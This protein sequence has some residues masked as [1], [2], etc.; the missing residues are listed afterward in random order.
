MPLTRS[1]DNPW[2]EIRVIVRLVKQHCSVSEPTQIKANY[3]KKDN[4][5][6][7]NRVDNVNNGPPKKVSKL[8]FRASALLRSVS[9]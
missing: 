7:I 3:E 6:V 8:K 2:L 4:F 1:Q 5:G 9:S